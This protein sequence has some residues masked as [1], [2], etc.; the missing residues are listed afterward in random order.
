VPRFQDYLLQEH[1]SKMNSSKTTPRI[2][3]I[4]APD[5]NDY[6]NSNEILNAYDREENADDGCF[7]PDAL[8]EFINELKNTNKKSYH[9]TLPNYY[10]YGGSGSANGLL[11]DITLE[12]LRA[13]RVVIYDLEHTN[14]YKSD[15]KI[16]FRKLL[17]KYFPENDYDFNEGP[18]TEPEDFNVSV[19]TFTPTDIQKKNIIYYLQTLY[20]AIEKIINTD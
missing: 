8:Q 18:Y 16:K 20:D 12:W 4:I 17:A 9:L 19:M 11:W 10:F 6:L 2:R 13:N 15:G 1:A 7:S 5:V 14:Y 3:P